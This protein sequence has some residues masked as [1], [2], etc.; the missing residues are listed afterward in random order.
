MQKSMRLNTD[1]L[2]FEKTYWTHVSPTDAKSNARSNFRNKILNN[3]EIAYAD[4]SVSHL[5]KI[6]LKTRKQ[7]MREF[8]S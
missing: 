3:E 1:F 2:F 6:L 8:E 4:I 7:K 5:Y